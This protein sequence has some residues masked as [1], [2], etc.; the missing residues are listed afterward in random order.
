MRT[1]SEL[2]QLE[3]IEERFEYLRLDGIVGDPTFDDMRW[4]NQAFYRST[5]WRNMRRHIIVRDQGMDLGTPDR[6]I[7]D[8]SPLIHHMN[9]L[10]LEDITEGTPNLLD[11]EFLIC[12]GLRTHNAVHFGDERLLPQP[13][14]ERE[15]GDHFAWRRLDLDQV[16]SS[17]GS[18]RGGT[19]PR[20]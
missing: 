8:K 2:S 12:T 14:I 19:S 11:P 13:F 6:P 3:T 18:L 4:V 17:I 9:P 10:T 5:E 7:R 1:Y 16:R 15:A 20:R